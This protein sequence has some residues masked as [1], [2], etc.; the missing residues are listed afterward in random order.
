MTDKTRRIADWV[1][2]IRETIGNI[3]SD[4]G[5]LTKSEFREDGKSQRAVIK[6]LTDTGEA[7]NNIMKLAPGLRQSNPD[8]W[9]HLVDVYAMRIRLTHT[10]HRTNP[11]IVFDTVLNDLPALESQLDNIRTAFDDSE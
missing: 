2:D 5:T 10:Y 11:N 9:Q 3:R 4:M 8:A 7:A 1:K 6:G